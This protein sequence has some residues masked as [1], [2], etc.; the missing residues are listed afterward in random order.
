MHNFKK[1][2][3]YNI[4]HP[5]TCQKFS[6]FHTFI[7]QLKISYC[8]LSENFTIPIRPSVAYVAIY[9]MEH[10]GICE[11]HPQ[12]HAGSQSYIEHPLSGELHAK[13]EFCLKCQWCSA[14]GEEGRTSRIHLLH[15]DMDIFMNIFALYQLRCPQGILRS[16][17]PEL[18]F[19][20]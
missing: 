2:T 8:L 18:P 9:L 16:N 6:I 5:L 4:Q 12:P 3:L 19:L 17:A 13:I 11:Q 20:Y 15:A 10:A 14:C 7:Q 1:S